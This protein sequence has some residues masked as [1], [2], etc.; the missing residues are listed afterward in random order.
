MFSR[1]VEKS[2]PRPSN[3]ANDLQTRQRWVD[4]SSMALEEQLGSA[5]KVGLAT[6]KQF[7][8]PELQRNAL[9]TH[10]AR[11][12]MWRDAVS[13]FGAQVHTSA[14]LYYKKHF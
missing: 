4:E 14:I 7:T 6:V 9:Q 5:A 10:C 8:K 1:V 2:I 12:G 11:L 3:F 13:K